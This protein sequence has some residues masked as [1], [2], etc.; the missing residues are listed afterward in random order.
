MHSLTTL[1]KDERTNAIWLGHQL[2]NMRFDRL[3]LLRRIKMNE[4]FKWD[5]TSTMKLDISL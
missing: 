2:K 1:D 5:A 3:C 4:I